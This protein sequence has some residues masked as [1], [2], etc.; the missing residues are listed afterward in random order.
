M[1]SLTAKTREHYLAQDIYNNLTIWDYYDSLTIETFKSI[2]LDENCLF[3][4]NKEIEKFD[5]KNAMLG[6][7]LNKD[8]LT[9]VI[10]DTANVKMTIG[11]VVNKLKGKVIYLDTWSTNCGPCL[12]AMPLSK[13]LKEKLTDE[14]IEFVYIT[15]DKD[16][17]NLWDKVF[18]VSQTRKNH[19]RFEKEFNSKLHNMF[20]IRA[21]PT[22]LLI[23]KQGNL[24]S[25]NAE[26]PFN[27]SWQVNL[28][29]EEK[30]IELADK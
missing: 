18:E 3:I 22:Y 13:K 14:P 1:D 29:L 12:M 10:F 15:V 16:S 9:T 7:P 19:Y 25:Y 8:F 30:L 2:S 24:V 21:V 26:R 17:E 11:D 27:M 5:I 6:M 28:K 20:S 4:I 23:D